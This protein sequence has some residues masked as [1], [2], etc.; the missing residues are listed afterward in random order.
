MSGRGQPAH[1]HSAAG[2]LAG[3][4]VL[5]GVA[6]LAVMADHWGTSLLYRPATN[7]IERSALVLNANG[8]YGVLIF[9]VVSGFVITRTIMQ[10]DGSAFA[11]D[12]RAFYLR[13]AGRILPLYFLWLSL[14]I[15]A[16]GVL[17]DHTVMADFII[18][19]PGARFD[20]IFWASILTFTFNYG[21]LGAA[22]LWGLHWDIFWSLCV[23]EQFYALFPALLRWSKSEARLLPALLILYLLA[24]PVRAVVYLSISSD[25]FSV[26]VP[27]PACVDLLAAGV[28]AALVAPRIR[29]SRS[30]AL[31]ATAAASTFMPLSIW[32]LPVGILHP[33]VIALGMVP[34]LWAAHCGAIF[35]GAPWVPLAR[36]GELS[37]GMYLLH[38]VVLYALAP[39]L[40]GISY[41][42]GY[43]VFIAATAA[44]A[45]ASYALFERPANR[46][47]RARG[48]RP[49]L[50]TEA[51]RPQGAPARPWR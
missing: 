46:W 7:L 30:Q 43:I 26:M 23:E 27:L 5:R 48:I 37:Y 6:I 10:R 25:W 42:L 50:P 21:A 33:T 45:Q 16:V 12:A 29:W 20:W 19:R 31:Y 11:V 32:L 13:R 34:L 47:I 28:F 24:V 17:C 3:V 35:R 41:F 51:V 4:D 38:P 1:S 14:G 39:W 8:R 2:R 49:T 40:G 18:H 22:V 44:V 15:V 9:F 36:I